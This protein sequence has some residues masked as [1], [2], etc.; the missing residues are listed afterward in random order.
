MLMASSWERMADSRLGGLVRAWERRSRAL[1]VLLGTFGY[2]ASLSPSLIPRS[3]VMQGVV[4]GVSLAAWYAVGVLLGRA[5]RRFRRW[6]IYA[7]G[8]SEA[9]R[10]AI[11]GFADS[12]L[13]A[14]RI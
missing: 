7:G 10:E 12:Y 5:W 6:S 14:H 4:S 13:G 9:G 2:A 3:P 11:A 1:A 8:E